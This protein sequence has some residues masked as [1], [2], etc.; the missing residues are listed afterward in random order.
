M[1][2]LFDDQ[3]FSMMTHGG[4]A[5]YHYELIK[6][7]N[8]MNVDTQLPLF[9]SNNY[10]I[11]KKDISSH[12]NSLPFNFKLFNRTLP[13]FNR[14]FVE[15]AILRQNYDVFHPTN[16]DV[17]FLEKIKKKPFVITVHDMITEIYDKDNYINKI[18]RKLIQKADKIIA[19]SENTKKDILKFVSIDETKI[20]VVYHG[21]TLISDDELTK[22]KK[23]NYVPYFLYVGGRQHYKNFEF[24]LK[25]F[26]VISQKYR[27]NLICTGSLF[28]KKEEYLLHQYQVDDLVKAY[29]FKNDRDMYQLYRNAI[30]LVY[31]S[32]YEGFGMPILEAFAFGCPVLLS[33]S[34]CFPEI[35]Q[36]AG[37]Y[38]SPSEIDSLIFSM[39]QIIFDNTLRECLIN[40]GHKRV[41][42]FSWEKTAESTIDV[43]K[44][45]I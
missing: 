10:Y 24:L 42:Q 33:K 34:S 12:L 28:T 26:A 29:V 16:Y 35:A 7:L 5:R 43:Y 39:E 13:H 17:Y 20:D 6:S 31:P 27:V 4:V 15:R 36:D 1:N 3:I 2:I 22:S 37:L 21:Y 9:F 18:K 23:N 11:R 30:S 25:A 40:K 41:S 44:S 14:Y 8:N 38:F 19:V 32:L 45:V